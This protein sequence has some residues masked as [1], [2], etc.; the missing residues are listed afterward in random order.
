MDDRQL[1]SVLKTIV[2]SLPEK[3]F[4]WHLDGSANLRVQGIETTVNDVDICADDAGMQTLKECLK[5]YFIQERQ[6]PRI[7]GPVLKFGIDCAEVEVYNLEPRGLGFFDSIARTEWK[8]VA[9]NTMP[10]RKAIE[11]YQAI[12]R[13]EK[14]ILIKRFI[15]EE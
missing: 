1:Y 9:L 15:G 11:F 2:G 6:S 13:P 3:D 5:G 7:Q 8:G 14:V 12:K 4:V 10:L